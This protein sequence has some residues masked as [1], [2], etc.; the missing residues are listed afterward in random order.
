MARQVKHHIPPRW[1]I[2]LGISLVTIIQVV[3]HPSR[4]Q[5]SRPPHLSLAAQMAVSNEFSWPDIAAE[6]ANTGRSG[7]KFPRPS[8]DAYQRCLFLHQTIL[9]GI[10]LATIIR[11]VKTSLQAN[12]L[13]LHLLAAQMAMNNEFSQ[14]DIAAELN[15]A[16]RSSDKFPQ[17]SLDIYG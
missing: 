2:L 3:K 1:A 16:G 14:P 11:V 5:T 4:L 13:P 6:L 12:W 8:L 10:P 9:P 17:P 7:D 15:N